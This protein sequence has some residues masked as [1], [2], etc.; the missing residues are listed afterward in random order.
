MDLLLPISR[1]NRV[2]LPTFGRP[3]IASMGVAPE[4]SARFSSEDSV[5]VFAKVNSKR[6][7]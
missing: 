3:T 2:L 5:E 7:C 6:S 4:F 1:L